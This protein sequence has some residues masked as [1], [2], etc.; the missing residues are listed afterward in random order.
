MQHPDHPVA[1]HNVADLPDA[2]GGGL[3]LARFPKTVWPKAENGPIPIRTSNGSEVRFVT[4]GER[5]R[6][7]LRSLAQPCRLVVFRGNHIHQV[8]EDAADGLRPIELWLPPLDPN[9]RRDALTTGGFAP[10][11]IRLHSVGGTLAFHGIEALGGALRPPQPEELPARHWLAYGS[12]ITQ[13]ANTVD[14]YVNL[15]GQ[16]LEADAL[17]LG[18]GGSCWCEPAIADFIASLPDIDVYSLELG[19]NMNRADWDNDQFRKRTHYLLDQ[20][21]EKQSGKPVFLFT[22]FNNRCLHEVEPTGLQR[23]QR[24][25]NAILREAAEDRPDQVTLIDGEALIPDFRG[26][27]T[28]LLHPESFAYARMAIRLADTMRQQL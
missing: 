8:I 10:E 16:L 27:R 24:E 7:Y 23:D 12:S 17:N 26:F 6:V 15:T 13:G 3:H 11:V 19:I 20:L 5:V 9:W 21:A 25:K 14:N 2:P 4:T 1:F 22:I 28:D 18:M